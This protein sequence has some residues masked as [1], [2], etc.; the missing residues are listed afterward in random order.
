MM[1]MRSGSTRT[2]DLPEMPGPFSTSLVGWIRNGCLVLFLILGAAGVTVAQPDG[3][4][5]LTDERTEEQIGSDRPCVTGHT[6]KGGDGS[7]TMANHFSGECQGDAGYCV[8]QRLTGSWD[9]PP[10]TLVP[11]E[12]L[13]MTIG[14]SVSLSASG[15][16][17][18]PHYGVGG[19]INLRIDTE[20]GGPYYSQAANAQGFA[21]DSSWPRQGRET[22][23][24][25][26][27]GGREGGKIYLGLRVIGAGSSLSK[28]YVYDWKADAEP[29]GGGGVPTPAAVG[30]W[31]YRVQGF[32]DTWTLNS[33]GTATSAHDPSAHGRWKMVGDVLVVTWPNGWENRYRIG[34]G[35]G[36]FEGEDLDPRKVS[37]RGGTITRMQTAGPCGGGMDSRAAA[38]P[39][40][41]NWHAITRD[42]RQ[43]AAQPG[44]VCPIG[45]YPPGSYWVLVAS[46]GEDGAQAPENW[47]AHGPFTF[48][49]H[50]K[51]KAEMDTG[52]KLHVRRNAADLT[53]YHDPG[54]NAALY[55]RNMSHLQWHALCVVADSGA[56]PG[57]E[58]AAAEAGEIA[59][60]WILDGAVELVFT[61]PVS[62]L[63]GAGKWPDQARVELQ[64]VRFDGTTLEFLRP[65]DDGKMNPQLY[66]G[67]LSRTPDGKLQLQGLYSHTWKGYDN[68]PKWGFS[69]VKVSGAR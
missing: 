56:K 28:T 43:F 20:S 32:T 68:V 65:L 2:R 58:A 50:D 7:V 52:A 46:L 5:I 37:H 24:W 10:R 63:R 48:F 66:R 14:S 57:A 59:G 29:T 44:K 31:R 19:S 45:T 36:P 6:L 17:A 16:K 51:W 34:P 38:G 54:P 22:T 4:W 69:A 8:S 42:Q 9:G 1:S 15:C 18:V 11:G 26:V 67:T 47:E 27:G 35:S 41:C 21:D 62:K 55:A 49:S 33:D 25:K 23:D 64:D 30:E 53:M 3:A 60:K 61:G 39:D 40:E 12:V 13:R